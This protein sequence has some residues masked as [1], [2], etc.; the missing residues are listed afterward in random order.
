MQNNGMSL[1]Y[2]IHERTQFDAFL[3]L[4]N[5]QSFKKGFVIANIGFQKIKQCAKIFT[6]KSN[7]NG[8]LWAGTVICAIIGISV[9]LATADSKACTAVPTVVISGNA[10]KNIH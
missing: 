3:S 10:D 7:H 8:D 4:I 6:G 9:L 1:S 5:R 2:R